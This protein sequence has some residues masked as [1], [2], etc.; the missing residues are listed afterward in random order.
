VL[1]VD[2]EVAIRDLLIEYVRLWGYRGIGAADGREGLALARRLH[3]AVAILD[4]VMA[5]LGG[6]EVLAALKADPQTR[7][8]PVLLHSVTDDPRQGLALGAVDYLQKPVTGARLREAI[9]RAIDRRPTP[10]WVIDADPGREERLAR[11]LGAGAFAVYGARTLAEVQTIRLT[12]PA[13]ILLGPIL[14]DGTTEG[15]LRAWRH[16]PAFRDTVVVLAGEWPVEA[17]RPAESQGCRVERSR[18]RRSADLADQVRAI[19][20]AREA[21][22]RG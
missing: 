9:E 12:A 7:H 22:P 5:S 2:D 4:V 14:P 19:V 13:V 18:G 8:I 6:L 21:P 3:P 16:D 11:E 15:L 10:V 20:A 1:I 17:E